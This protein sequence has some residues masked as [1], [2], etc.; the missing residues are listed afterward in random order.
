M[1]EKILVV[2]DETN[3]VEILTYNLKKAGYETIQANDG[4]TGLKMALE[5]N[6]DLVM[7]DIMMP[8]M[9]GYEVCRQLRMH[10]QVPVI[11]LT[12]RAEE[13][14]KVLSFE[15]GADDYI[16]KP[17]SLSVLR[18]RVEAVLRRHGGNAPALLSAGFRL[19]T[20]LC[21]LYCSDTEIPVSTTEFRLLHYFMANAGQVLTKEQILA[22]LWDNQ[23]QFVDENTL[24]VN[25]SRLRAKIEADPKHPQHIKTVRGMGYI[26]GS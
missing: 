20:R 23:G 19:D 2:D 6:P 18:A 10:S 25:I 14:D 12:A 9:D 5:E 24:S 4:E 3:I 1:P 17:F 15:L 13:T 22:V 16:T 8:K 7:L 11:M 21:K 26:W